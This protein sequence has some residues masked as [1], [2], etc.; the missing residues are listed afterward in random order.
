MRAN[1]P[2]TELRRYYERSDLPCLIVQAAKNS[3]KWKVNIYSLDYHH[4]LPIFV[5]GLREV[6]EPY[7]FIAEEGVYDLI[8]AGGEAKVFPVIPQLILPL[9][10]ALATRDEAVMKR[11]LKVIGTIASLG[12]AAGASLIPYY[13]QLLPIFNLF[14]SQGHNIGQNIDYGQ[15]FGRLSDII[16]E[17][18]NR[19][20]I[21]GGPDALINI[22]LLVPTYES[23]VLG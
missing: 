6:E 4:Y 11:T 7:R 14:I 15:R 13:R 22:K 3:L 23:A 12:P 19:M 8:R 18:L 21:N 20:E 1:P 5:S 9:K 16:T 2:N 17:T 10:E